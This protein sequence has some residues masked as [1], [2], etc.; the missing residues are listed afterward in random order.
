MELWA[1]FSKFIENVYRKSILIQIPSFSP[2]ILLGIYL[3]KIM[4]MNNWKYFCFYEQ[5][6]MYN[7]LAL[8]LVSFW[9]LIFVW[10]IN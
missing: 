5:K 9:M 6:K 7:I 8:M 3:G 10:Y 2:A 4:T 1:I